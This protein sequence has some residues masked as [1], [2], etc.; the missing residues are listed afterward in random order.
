MLSGEGNHHDGKLR[1]LG[2]V[3]GDGV[4]QGEFVELAIIVNHLATFELDAELAFD[5][6]DLSDLADVAIENLFVVIVFGLNHL[7]ANAEVRAE[8]F[9]ARFFG[10]RR[11]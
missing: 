9:D 5:R 1:A 4:S 11:I 7:V 10:T 8:F 2:F 6:I 3:N